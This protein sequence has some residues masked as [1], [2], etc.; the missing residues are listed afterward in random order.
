MLKGL[1]TATALRAR[2]LRRDAV[3]ERGDAYLSR[4]QDGRAGSR[5]VRAGSPVLSGLARGRRTGPARLSRDLEARHGPQ[6]PDFDLPS[7]EGTQ[8]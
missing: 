1:E 5:V 4:V 8:T 6:E 7:T 3:A 2:P